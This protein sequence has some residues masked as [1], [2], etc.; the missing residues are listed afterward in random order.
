MKTYFKHQLKTNAR[1][2]IILTVLSMLICFFVAIDSMDRVRS[3]SYVVKD[4]EYYIVT[5]Y[6]P[7]GDPKS[8]YSDTISH[9][10]FI[11]NEEIVTVKYRD[12][13]LAPSMAVLMVLA[14]GVPVWMFAFLK[15]KRNLDCCY[16]LPITR[17]GIGLTQYSVGLVAV[18][19]PF[20]CSYVLTLITN[21]SF[22]LF[23]ALGHGYLISHFG[24][25]LLAGFVIYSLSVFVFEKA[26]SVIDGV[27]FVVAYMLVLYVLVYDTQNIINEI[28]MLRAKYVYNESIK[29][30]AL[31][32]LV[33]FNPFYFNVS[34]DSGIPFVFFISL[35]EDLEY[36]A[37]TVYG[38]RM[39]RFFSD[40][41]NI[42]WLVFWTVVGIM[43]AVGAV[44]GF[45]K[46]SAQAAEEISNSIFG[47]KLLIP[48]VG[49][50]Y[51]V[52][53]GIFDSD[54][55]SCLAM[56]VACAVG[57]TVYRRGVKYKKSDYIIIGIM[58]ALTV[59]SLY[60]YD[61]IEEILGL[62]P[63]DYYY[64]NGRYAP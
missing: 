52:P 33:Y 2:I 54:A 28:G 4:G 11:T 3:V 59:C 16:S 24:V 15:K 10:T 51:I 40:T 63:T 14:V 56:M 7:N 29:N 1:A 19:V 39:E 48:L 23:G 62:H 64:S 32:D 57:Y 45:G 5:S 53:Y 44:W 12:L 20:V 42:V 18:Y 30:G 13:S 49:F 22:G 6:Y 38:A 17:R 9:E 47:Y 60:A 43:T 46:K 31:R 26:N 50:S 25:C 36:S 41:E 58:L 35:L 61:A 21:A 8:Y 34:E 55:T 27:V 37:E